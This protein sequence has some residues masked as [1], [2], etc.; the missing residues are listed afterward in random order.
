VGSLSGNSLVANILNNFQTGIHIGGGA[1]SVTDVTTFAEGNSIRGAT[2]GI[3]S[4]GNPFN[5][6]VRQA[7]TNI[8]DGTPTLFYSLGGGGSRFGKMIAHTAPTAVMA[9]ASG[10]AGKIP[11]SCDGFEFPIANPI[12]IAPNAAIDG[13]TVP[14]GGLTMF[15]LPG[16]CFGRVKLQAKE[17]SPGTSW[18]QISATLLWDGTNFTLTN[19][20]S[21]VGG[22]ITSVTLANG[23]TAG[24]GACYANIFASAN[25]TLQAGWIEFDGE[26]WDA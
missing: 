12:A 21:R 24:A 18:L 26:Y 5:G 19:V 13:G 11:S 2:Y 7:G 25:L 17:A 15:H 8:C 4:W 23:G 1:G 9:S 14:Y 16:P 6:T 10:H 3:T 22:L 20:L